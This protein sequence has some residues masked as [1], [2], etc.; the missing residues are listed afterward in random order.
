[1]TNYE[2]YY[3]HGKVDKQ[4]GKPMCLPN[5]IDIQH[6]YRGYMDGYGGSAFNEPQPASYNI[7]RLHEK[8]MVTVND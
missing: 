8:G 5:T 2:T 1:M 7:D 4:A 6:A 3:Y